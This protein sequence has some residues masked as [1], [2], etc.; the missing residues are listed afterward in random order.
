MRFWLRHNDEVG[1]FRG[2]SGVYVSVVHGVGFL[3]MAREVC[4]VGLM[5]MFV[6]KGWMYAFRVLVFGW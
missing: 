4:E 2:D 6:C 3:E 1:D 5:R